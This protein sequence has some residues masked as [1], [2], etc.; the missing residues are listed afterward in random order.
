MTPRLI[1]IDA[2]SGRQIGI[3]K[4]PVVK[5]TMNLGVADNAVVAGPGIS[6]NHI[7]PVFRRRHV[8]LAAEHAIRLFEQEVVL[9]VVRRMALHAS[10]SLN[11]I[12][13]V[14]FMLIEKRPGFLRMALG[15]CPGQIIG[16]VILDARCK[17]VTTEAGHRSG[18]ERMIGDSD[19]CGGF[20][21]MTGGTKVGI[22]VLKHGARLAVDL[23]AG[24][25][26]HLHFGMSIESIIIQE[27]APYMTLPAD[28]IGF[29]PGHL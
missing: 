23:M 3:Q 19:E 4:Q 21:L 16:Q 24:R 27:S 26:V 15:A 22:I 9:T 17:A 13:R 10:A 14:G 25:T 18:H 1:T 11:R 20:I 7:I 5:R 8:T 28:A 12:S 2:P 29:I 6:V